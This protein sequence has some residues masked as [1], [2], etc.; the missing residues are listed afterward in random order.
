[1]IESGL[2]KAENLGGNAFLNG[3]MS[4]PFLDAE[5]MR[6]LEGNKDRD[7][8]IRLMK[9]WHKGYYNANVVAMDAM[10]TL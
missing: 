4:A 10:P 2:L 1:M 7:N 8:G 3:A 5:M 6:M 9:A